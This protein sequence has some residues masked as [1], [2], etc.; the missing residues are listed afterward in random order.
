M[1]SFA[2]APDTGPPEVPRGAWRSPEPPGG[3]KRAEHIPVLS[4]NVPKPPKAFLLDLQGSRAKLRRGRRTR[5][6]EQCVVLAPLLRGPD[7]PRPARRG[8]GGLDIFCRSAGGR[9]TRSYPAG[10]IRG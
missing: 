6:E 1:V 2:P 9:T 5:G 10:R 4:K 7:L 8:D 3:Q